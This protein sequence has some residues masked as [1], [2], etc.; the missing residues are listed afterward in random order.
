MKT[1]DFGLPPETDIEA[2]GESESLVKG[3]LRSRRLPPAFV[4]MMAWVRDG[5]R[6]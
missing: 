2:E 6:Y 4:D 1:M 3:L 5:V